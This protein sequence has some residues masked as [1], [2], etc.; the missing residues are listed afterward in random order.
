[1]IGQYDPGGSNPA[2]SLDG[3]YIYPGG[4]KIP[5][6]FLVCWWTSIHPSLS[7]SDSVVC[8]SIP[9]RVDPDCHYLK[10]VSVT[11]CIICLLALT[12]SCDHF[13]FCPYNALNR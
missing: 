11:T 3:F 2:I 4:V 10:I 5:L 7:C 9:S 8:A 13:P 1:M 12:H 6:Y